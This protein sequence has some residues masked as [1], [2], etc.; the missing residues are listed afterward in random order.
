M[1]S[2]VPRIKS[3]LLGGFCRANGSALGQG[4]CPA[5]YIQEADL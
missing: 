1:A 2:T 4:Y 3:A 5:E